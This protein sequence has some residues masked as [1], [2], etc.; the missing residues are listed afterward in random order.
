MKENNEVVNANKSID[1]DFKEMK[2][3]SFPED[4][5]YENGSYYCRCVF[6]DKTFVGYKRRVCC[7]I[8]EGEKN[9]LE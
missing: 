3:R 4:E 6:C 9:E 5:K 8:C 2:Q 7:K 1:L